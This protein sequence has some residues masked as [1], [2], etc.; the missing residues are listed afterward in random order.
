MI[1]R[2]VDYQIG[3]LSLLHILYLNIPHYNLL[4]KEEGKKER[5]KEEKKR[6]DKRGK[7]KK[8]TNQCIRYSPFP[9]LPFDKLKSSRQRSFDNPPGSATRPAV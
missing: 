7:G 3:S 5:R 9:H 1:H 2:V 6:R 8:G 4:F